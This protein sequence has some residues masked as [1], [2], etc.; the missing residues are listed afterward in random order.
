M[1]SALLFSIAAYASDPVSVAIEK[2][3][4]LAVKKDRAGAT[5]VLNQAIEATTP[6]LKGRSRL[7]ETQMNIAKI[8]FTDKGQKL[9]EA[10]QSAMYENPDIALNH[11]RDATVLEGE[12]ILLIGN[13][14]RIQLAK[15]DCAGAAQT[16]KKARQL[17]PHASEPAVLELRA[18]V[19]QK[20]FEAFREKIK[21]TPPLDKGQDAYVQYLVAQDLLQ[22]KMWRKASD[23]LTRVS[24]EEPHF[25][26][27]YYLLLRAG[28]EIGRETEPWAQ[29]YVSL[30]KGLTARERKKFSLE[31]R[32]CV[33]MKE[34]EDELAKKTDL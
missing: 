12:N 16:V 33:N 20:D 18:L 10:G 2:A 21:S 30:C 22:Q 5:K 31:P 25:P 19:C 17:Y 28:Q 34:V 23:I 3:Q 1:W 4:S 27:T 29:R 14:A 15:Q 24:E 9:F 32:L 26:E 7:I 13:I 8:F 6:P 11:Y